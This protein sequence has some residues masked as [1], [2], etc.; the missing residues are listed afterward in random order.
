M[1][2]VLNISAQLYVEI[3]CRFS[4]RFSRKKVRNVVCDAEHLFSQNDK[5]FNASGL[6]GVSPYEQ[7]LQ[8]STLGK[9]VKKLS[10][11]IHRQCLL[12]Q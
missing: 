1:I 12:F 6:G 9:S 5:F 11:D 10:V 7:F 8:I 4:F 2:S 3:S